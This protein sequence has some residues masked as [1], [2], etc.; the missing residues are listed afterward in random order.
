MAAI[1][2]ELAIALADRGHEVHVVSYETPFRLDR[3]RGNLIFHGVEVGEYPLF[4]HQPYTLNLTNKLVGL[5]ED[6]GIECIHSHYAIPHAQSAWMAREVLR[7][8]RQLDVALAC[9]LHGTDITLVGRLKSFYELTRFTIAKQ[10]LLTA[11]SDFLARDTE[12]AFRIDTARVSVIPNFVDLERF[13]PS[14][15]PEVRGCLAPNGERVIVHVSNFRPVKRIDHVIK[16][17]HVLNQKVPATLA[18]VGEGPDLRIAEEMVDELGIRERVHFL[19]RE[20]RIERV[21]QAAD[22]MLL[23]S[24][25]ESFGLAALEAMACG[26]P[27]LA[28]RVGGLPEVI[29]DGFSGILCDDDEEVCLGSLGAALLQDDER[30][31]AMAKAARAHAERFDRKPVIDA[32]EQALTGLIAGSDLSPP[33]DR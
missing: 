1:A 6:H 19:G 18:L 25:T 10:D 31:Q 9:T 29:E 30:Y 23:P 15:A 26:C 12:E 33:P 3:W 11:P 24:K 4:R 2:T 7:E 32:Y 17:F 21:L 22:L 13:V 8:E 14:D 28:Y 20:E 16:S 5:V 27:V